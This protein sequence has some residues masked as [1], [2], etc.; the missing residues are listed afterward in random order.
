VLLLI[1][2]SP[3]L[4]CLV[5]LLRSKYIFQHRNLS[6][7][8]HLF[9][10]YCE[11]PILIPIKTTGKIAVFVILISNWGDERFRTEW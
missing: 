8:Q 2:W 9:F 6:Y 5:L 3:A 11:G 1:M 4:T 7:S 10:A